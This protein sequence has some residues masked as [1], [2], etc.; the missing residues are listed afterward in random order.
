MKKFLL[1]L[2][3]L[4]L[5][6]SSHATAVDKE[7]YWLFF[8][9]K[10][11]GLHKA[12]LQRLEEQLDERLKWRRSKVVY[13]GD[14][15]VDETDLPV[16]AG[17]IENLTA[18]GLQI[19]VVSKWLNAVS[20]YTT[21]EQAEDLVAL[22]FVKNV[23]KVLLGK[24][25]PIINE[26][27]FLT[28]PLGETTPHV[29]DYG[30]S[31]IQNEQIRIPDIHGVGITG[32][33]VRIAV[34]DTGF[35]LEHSA[36]AHIDIVAAYDFIN[37]D[38]DVDNEDGDQF[39]QNRHGTQVLSVIGGYAPGELIGAAF[40]AS[41]LL[42][43]T[44]DIRSET[45]V[46][47]D[48]WIA[49]AEW[50]EVHAA[51]IITSSL[52]YLD[53]YDYEDLDGKT[54]PI[55]I[56]ADMA[57]QKG[58]V[59][60]T[61]A[62]NEGDKSWYYITAPADGIDVIA[63]G[64]VNSAGLLAGFSSRGPTY[65][66]RVKPEVVAMGVGCYHA[67]PY[68][69][70]GRGNGTSF[71]CPLVA[72]TAALILSAHPHLTPLEVRKALTGTAA[73]A[74]RPDNNYGHGLI[75]ALDAVNYHGVVTDP[76]E[77]NRLVSVYPNPFS[78][79]AHN[80]LY[81]LLDLQEYSPVKIELYNILGHHYGAVINTDIAGSKEHPVPWSATVSDKTLPSGVYFFRIHIGSYM[82]TGK[83]TILN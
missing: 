38:E 12:A 11:P 8:T 74:T 72:G 20:V 1:C 43:K 5:L 45:Q 23:Q 56:A 70:F 36:F 71:S 68:T 83:F 58:I 42:A 63:V 52:G 27:D 66:G 37:N 6:T 59:V 3:G 67:Y 48:N 24:K 69:G 34:F 18:R 40:D 79:H 54:A 25:K 19:A 28:K 33:N 31:L 50:A 32:H 73:Q 16:Y 61:S 10:G 39:D 41:F 7:K 29:L 44:E 64:A 57:V 60:I 22:P 51:D 35:N 75:N 78:Y 9:D 46:E 13:P 26:P 55:T 53:W 76:A 62:G 65:D 49:A 30:P 4:W 14:P 17:Y 47:E 21:P 2:L 80:E 82:Q 15:L 81:F 77:F